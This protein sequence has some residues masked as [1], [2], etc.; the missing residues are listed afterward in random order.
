MVGK[1]VVIA[2]PKTD[3]DRRYNHLRRGI[4]VD[5]FKDKKLDNKGI[6]YHRFIVKFEKHDK[7]SKWCMFKRSELLIIEK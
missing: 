3:Y 4:V 5:E 1:R 2:Y 6:D 7:P